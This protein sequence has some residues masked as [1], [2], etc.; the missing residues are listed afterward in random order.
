MRLHS[1]ESINPSG[2]LRSSHTGSPTCLLQD[3]DRVSTLCPGPGTV[4]NTEPVPRQC[5]LREG[6][7]LT[8]AVAF[9]GVGE[10][11]RGVASSGDR[12][13]K[14]LGTV[15]RDLKQS[16]YG[17]KYNE[18]C[19]SYSERHLHDIT[20]LRGRWETQR[21]L[22]TGLAGLT[23]LGQTGWVTAPGVGEI[24]REAAPWSRSLG[25]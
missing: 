23:L 18:R 13:L 16:R 19:F 20:W 22:R 6:G 12:L 17:G 9:A 7:G 14:L 11:G 1:L 8:H 2:G 10:E 25:M 5:W 3:K 15:L 4:A 24:P 21:K